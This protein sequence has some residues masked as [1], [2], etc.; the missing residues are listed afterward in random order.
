MSR[1][2][3]TRIALLGEFRHIDMKGVSPILLVLF[4]SLLL[5]IIDSLQRQAK[6]QTI[7]ITV[8]KKYQRTQL[9]QHSGAMF[10]EFSEKVFELVTSTVSRRVDVVFDVYREVSIKNVERLKRMSSSVGVQYI[11]LISLVC[12]VRTA[13]YGPSF[14]LPF[15][16]TRKEKTRIRNLP[17]GPSKRG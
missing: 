5:I 8:T 15:K 10:H 11:P 2:V 3:F 6:T 13:S 17:Y 1:D 12:S 16:K 4:I 9:N 7:P 14:F